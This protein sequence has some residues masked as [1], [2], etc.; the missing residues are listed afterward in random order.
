[1]GLLVVAALNSLIET[2]LALLVETASVVP[3]LA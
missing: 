3:T 1:L 2:T